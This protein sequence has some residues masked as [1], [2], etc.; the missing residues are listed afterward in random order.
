VNWIHLKS[1][2]WLRWRLSRNQWTRGGTANAVLGILALAGGMLAACAAA[3]GGVLVGST[4]LAEA[5]PEKVRMVWDGVVGAFLFFWLIGLITDI[6][7]SESLDLGRLLHLPI[8]LKQLF[9]INYLAS[10]VTISLVI[11]VPAM[12]GLSAG[13]IASRGP[14]FFLLIP[15]VLGFI[16]MITAWTYC[17]RGWLVSMMVNKRRRRAIIM[18]VT[19]GFVLLAQLPNLYFNVFRHHSENGGE[20]FSD[21]DQYSRLG[22]T[23]VKREAPGEFMEAHRYLPPLWLAHGARSLAQDQPGPAL[24]G[25]AG[26]FIIGAAGLFR[27]YRSTLRF[28]RGEENGKTK[29][30]AAGP[31]R[32]PRALNWVAFELP[33]VPREAAPLVL[34]SCRSLSRAP[35]V[36]MALVTP[37]IMLGIFASMLFSRSSVPLPEAINPILAAGAVAF[38]MFG[39]VQLM[40]NQFGFDRDGFRALVLLPTP[41]RYFLLGKNLSFLP[42]IVVMGFFFLGILMVLAGMAPATILAAGLQLITAFL[43]LALLGNLV[44]ILTPYR[45]ATGSLKPTKTPL[46]TTLMIFLTH[47]I[48]PFALLP[49]FVPP[50]SEVMLTFLY[51]PMVIPV[52]LL[53]SCLLIL[54]AGFVYRLSLPSLGALLQRREEAILQIVTRE[55]E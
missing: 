37:F 17:L 7:R 42:L 33:W 1:I 25:G 45:I 28:Y 30:A 41:R 8:S 50:L 5:A 21:S 36:K 2:L 48:F 53:L 23:I 54:A 34:A 39:M 10:H 4:A 51:G 19:A 13:L 44:S 35:E 9:T 3:L 31:G 18:G 20:I 29:A 40:F 16:F 12:L 22:E 26:L 15:V 47:M 6:Q 52:N 24:W 27:A 46:K 11:A 32:P 55:V 49:I 38:S 43:L 14:R